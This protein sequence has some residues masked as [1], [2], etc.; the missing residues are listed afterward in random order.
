MNVMI[1]G[2]QWQD[3]SDLQAYANRARV[4]ETLLVLPLAFV[5][6]TKAFAGVRKNSQ[7][8]EITEEEGEGV[9]R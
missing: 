2:F 1:R 7:L 8:N 4:L 9:N 5:H 3:F 6:S